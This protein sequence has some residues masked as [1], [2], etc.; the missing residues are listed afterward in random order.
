[1]NITSTYMMSL[2]VAFVVFVVAETSFYLIFVRL[3]FCGPGGP[4]DQWY[5]MHVL[6]LSVAC[7]AWLPCPACDN[8]F[9][10]GQLSGYEQNG[11]GN[12]ILHTGDRF[13]FLSIHIRSLDR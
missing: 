4:W 11:R 9:C 1:M 10:E 3:N 5:G 12:S 13:S 8:D 6:G 7:M 2:S